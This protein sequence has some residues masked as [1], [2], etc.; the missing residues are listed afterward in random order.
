MKQK[1]HLT[2]TWSRPPV[3]AL[4]FASFVATSGAQAIEV[5]EFDV[6]SFQGA[7]L[8]VHFGLSDVKQ[9][10]WGQLSIQVSVDKAQQTE[11]AELA[12]A[13]AKVRW[14][15]P[16]NGLVLAAIEGFK[17]VLTSSL[18]MVVD[19]QWASGKISRP[20]LLD[21][22]ASMAEQPL[23]V[24]RNDTLSELM[25]T[26]RYGVGTLAQRMVA[27]LSA[28]PSAF[29]GGN[30][31]RLRAGKSIALPSM[32]DILS[33]DAGEAQAMVNA[34]WAEF[35]AYRRGLAQGAKTVRNDQD[36]GSGRVE[37]QVQGGANV[38]QGDRLAVSQGASDIEQKLA[39]QQAMQDEAKRQTELHNNLKDL[40]EIQQDLSRVSPTGDSAEAASESAAAV[41]ST[42]SQ[43]EA[44]SGTASDS[45]SASGVDESKTSEA[46]KDDDSKV[47]AVLPVESGANEPE[48][49]KSL[50]S[51]PW[52]L[53][54]LGLLLALMAL[55]VWVRRSHERRLV[56]QAEAATVTAPLLDNPEAQS[57]NPSHAEVMDAPPQLQPTRSLQ[58]L[59]P[60]VDLDLPDLNLPEID[61]EGLLEAAKAALRSGE[62]ER[63]HELALMAL[64]SRDPS[65]QANAKALLE[66]I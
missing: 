1:Y 48:W 25:I 62:S 21:I 29:I 11:T 41:G 61:G 57:D 16:K 51:K 56:A 12:L 23:V 43:S 50:K 60:D 40:T 45:S 54:L 32:A 10:D 27:T 9:A 64:E 59:M 13:G 37:A 4:L 55:L 22:P 6:K 44:S 49:L 8:Y 39:A 66:R 15:R 24:F 26:H 42:T 58:S 38:P 28:N 2:P 46:N 17:P 65:I 36:G 30:L 53:P 14:Q 3:W 52:L 33:V 7:P 20:I 35:D 63:A 34:Q 19:I 47:N 31:H 5:G 18:P